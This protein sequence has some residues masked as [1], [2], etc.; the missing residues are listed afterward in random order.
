MNRIIKTAL[1]LSIGFS[2]CQQATPKF[3]AQALP[4][5]KILEAIEV[6]SVVAD[7]PVGFQ[8]LSTRDWQFIAYFNKHRALTVASRRTNE[9]KWTYQVLPSKVG[10]DSHNRIA[11]ALDRDQ[12]LHLSGNMHNDPL[13]YFKTKKP[14]DITSFERVL[15]MVAIQDELRCTYPNFIKNGNGELIYTY[16][17]GGSGNGI[18]FTNVYDEDTKSFQRLTDQPLFDGRGLMSAYASGPR[19]GP[20]SLFHVIWFWRDTPSC[21]TNHDLS[22]AQS[23]DLVNWE[24][25]SGQKINLPI[26]PDD[27]STVVDPVPPGGGVI[28]GGAQLFFNDLGEPFIAYMKYDAAGKS[29]IFLA[30]LSGGAWSTKQISNWDYRWAFSGPGSIDFHIRLKK[31]YF[32]SDGQ[33]IIPYFHI[34]KGDGELVVHGTNLVTLADRSVSLAKN[35]DYPAELLDPSSKIDSVSVRWLTVNKPS[36][37]HKEYYALRWETMG[38]RRFYQAPSSPI[39][40]SVMTL[41]LL[42]KKE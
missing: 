2:A 16:R 20:D 23:P 1:I 4:T 36:K 35:I 28:N 24:T 40:P 29:Q 7:F 22:Y 41:Y 30:T 42:Q 19:L 39:K 32:N 38:K 26:S 14:L 3:E 18:N 9:K 34:K 5:F 25:A 11:M 33:V 37:N 15:P 13:V 12:C 8:F 21:E 6:D 17:K 31:G 10:W 27:T